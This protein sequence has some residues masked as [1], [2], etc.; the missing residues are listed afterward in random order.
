MIGK[1]RKI[2]I[3]N[4]DRSTLG[5]LSNLSDRMDDLLNLIN[6]KNV[7]DEIINKL[8]SI[9]QSIIT[10]KETALVNPEIITKIDNLINKVDVLISNNDASQEDS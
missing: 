6:E 9:E 7:N 5:E 8:R 4:T 2:Q 10:S 1:G 3:I